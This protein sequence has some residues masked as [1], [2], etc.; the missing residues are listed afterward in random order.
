MVQELQ[1]NEDIFYRVQ[2]ASRQNVEPFPPFLPSPPKFVRSDEFRSFFL[3]KGQLSPPTLSTS[4]NPPCCAFDLTALSLVAY[5]A[6]ACVAASSES[7]RD[8]EARI[9]AAIEPFL[10]PS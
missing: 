7:V 1:L 9:Y 4:H 3:T 6:R 8:L 2:V 10:G 5:A